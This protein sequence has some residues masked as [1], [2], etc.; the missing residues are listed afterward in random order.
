[1]NRIIA[2]LF[3]PQGGVQA[4]GQAASPDQQKTAL[5]EKAGGRV[6]AIA[7]NDSHLEV[8]FHLFDL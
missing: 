1:M 2:A 4:K 7:Q 5:I 8:D 6:A 3:S